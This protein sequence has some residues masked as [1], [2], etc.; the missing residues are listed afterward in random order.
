MNRLIYLILITIISLPLWC[1]A[2]VNHW[3]MVVSDNDSW[4]YII[5]DATTSSTWYDSSFNASSWPVGV[6]GFGYGDNDD[7]TIIPNNSSSIYFRK[8]FII[9][10]LR[11]E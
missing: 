4:N 9:H 1:E 6:G 7:N 8:N 11:A 2:Q 5:P 3:E 10:F